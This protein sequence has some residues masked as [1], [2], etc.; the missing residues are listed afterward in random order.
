MRIVSLVPSVTETLID[1]GLAD[2]LVGITRFCIHPANVVDD[3]PRVGGT[4]DPALDKIRAAAPDIIFFNEEENRR[5]DFEALAPTFRVHSGLIRT[6][7]QV[8]DSLRQIGQIC[9]AASIAEQR[10]C[11][12]EEALA[13]LDARCAGASFTFAYLIWR[14]PWMTLNSDTYVSD[15]L[16]RGGGRNVF[17]DLPM[18]Y[19]E[20]TLDDLRARRPNVVLLPDEP[21]PFKTNHAE[22]LAVTTGLHIDLISGDDACWHGVR[23]LRGV[24]LVG[25]LAQ[26][27]GYMKTV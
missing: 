26:R 2:Q 4:K 17:A 9:G 23:A 10:A 14:R 5:E 27:Y 21:F 24:D 1:F 11:A 18:R 15:L 13:D 12:L 16:T 3:L 19:P 20:I 25:Q 7:A 8:P 6:V 22:E